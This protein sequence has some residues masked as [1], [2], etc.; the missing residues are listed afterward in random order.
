MSWKPFR[1]HCWLCLPAPDSSPA[2]PVSLQGLVPVDTSLC[3]PRRTAPW[4]YSP[5]APQLPRWASWSW[6]PDE[7]FEPRSLPQ[8]QRLEARD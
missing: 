7:G 4:A 6:L 1:P 2:S 3:P 5:P 8:G